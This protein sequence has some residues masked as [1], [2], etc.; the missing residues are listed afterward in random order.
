METEHGRLINPLFSTFHRDPSAI[1]LKSQPLPAEPAVGH[2][3]DAAVNSPARTLG[4]PAESVHSYGDLETLSPKFSRPDAGGAEAPG[5][6][7]DPRHPRSSGRSRRAQ[8]SPRAR[9]PAA[10]AQPSPPTRLPPPGRRSSR[11]AL[12]VRLCALPPPLP[13]PEPAGRRAPAASFHKSPGAQRLPHSRRA[14]RPLQLFPAQASPA[15]T[16]AQLGRVESHPEGRGALA[17]TRAASWQPAGPSLSF[18]TCPS[19]P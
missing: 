15:P 16:A 2:M 8:A 9:S 6:A 7:R 12:R 3:L 18:S 17:A 19:S 14:Q 1:S 11:S 13:P 10:S 5:L 4:V